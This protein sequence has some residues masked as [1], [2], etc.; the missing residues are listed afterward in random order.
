MG[1]AFPL[2]GNGLQFTL[3]P[4]LGA[5]P[6]FGALMLG[7]IPSACFIGVQRQQ[8]GARARDVGLCRQS[9]S[10]H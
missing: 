5:A 9:V 4:L 10:E 8:R 7:M 1:T 6:N 2:V 3:L